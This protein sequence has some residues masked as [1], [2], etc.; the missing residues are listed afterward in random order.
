VETGRAESAGGIGARRVFLLAS[1]AAGV[2]VL[3]VGAV[4]GL[5]SGRLAADYWLTYLPGAEAVVHGLSPYPRYTYPPQIAFAYAPATLID[6]DV[7]AYI[8]VFV[9]AVLIASTLAVLRVRDPACYLAVFLWA[10]TWQ[11]LDMANITPALAL[12]LALAWRYRHRPIVSGVALGLIV[13]AKLFLWP[14]LFWT[15]VSRRLRAFCVALGLGL[16]VTVGAWGLIGFQ[17]LTQYPHLLR[18]LDSEYGT[19]GYS[20]VALSTAVGTGTSAGHVAACVVGAALLAAG[21]VLG[22]RGDDVSSFTLC[23][24]A[25]LALTPIVWLHYLI[26]LVV[27]LAIVRPAFSWLWLLPVGLWI[28]WAPVQPDVPGLVAPLLVAAIIV[29]AVV[30]PSIA[31][32]L[33]EITPQSPLRHA[34]P[35]DASF[36][37]EPRLVER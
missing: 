15:L 4:E 35:Q 8:S 12:G 29:Y 30:K 27:P 33:D 20:F 24:A 3:S 2:S 19:H 17:G 9:C 13:P 37:L 23:I 22:R 7:A 1:L 18:V 14:V 26:L 31:P 16:A 25:A 5:R 11:E 28:S 36:P 34:R 10:P 6:A 32:R 21:F